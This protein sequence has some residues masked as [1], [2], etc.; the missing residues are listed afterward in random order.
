MT[1]LTV[2]RKEIEALQAR[3]EMLVEALGKAQDE[4]THLSCH[5]KEAYAEKCANEIFNNIEQ[6]LANVRGE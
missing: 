1:A 4:L 5:T 3:E 6:A 2:S